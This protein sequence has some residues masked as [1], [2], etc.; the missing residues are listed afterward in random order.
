MTRLNH[1]ASMNEL[2]A[3]EGVFTAAQAE[4]LGITNNALSKAMS[5]RRAERIV[6]GAYRLA[7]TQSLPSDELA[8]IWK[9]TNPSKLT[10]ERAYEWDGVVIGGSSACALLDI[11]D[12]HLSPY[13]IYAPKRINSRNR[14][15][16]FGVRDISREDVIW[17]H[18]MPVTRKERTI[19]D[20]LIDQEDASLAI[21]AFN[22][23]A[24]DGIGMGRLRELIRE[25]ERP[26]K[27][28][29]TLELARNLGAILPF[30]GTTYPPC[31][32][33]RP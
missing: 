13:R 9:L 25:N 28:A 19:V 17:L 8:A 18:G 26:L 2:S 10:S 14:S 20:L 5:S 23:A 30:S 21:A 29:G 4:R 22:D 24:R 12:F 31:R 32:S 7:G 16:R 1:I 15:A 33:R 27:R 3:S 6:H 11:G